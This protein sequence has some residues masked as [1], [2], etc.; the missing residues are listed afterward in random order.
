HRLFLV[1]VLAGG[2]RVREVLAV[3]VLRGGDQDGVD[4]LVFK[5]TTMIQ[6]RFGVG[7]DRFGG[8]EGFGVDV[9]DT[10][11][12]DIGGRDRLLKNFPAA[13]AGSDDAD[14]DA[15]VGSEDV[16]C[17]ER[18]GQTGRDVTDEI[19]TRLHGDST[20]SGAESY[21]TGATGPG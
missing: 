19:T 6:I 17:G 4:I 16:G 12:F 7:R 5:K 11:A 9:G 10:D 8:F 3:E 20:P 1:D 21:Y 15:V 13:V 18:A 2:Q 14:A